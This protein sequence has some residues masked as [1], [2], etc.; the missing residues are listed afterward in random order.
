MAELYNALIE[1]GE[2]FGIAKVGKYAVDSLRQEKGMR[3]WG[4]EV[5][6]LHKPAILM[7]NYLHDG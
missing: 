6:Q 7:F 3:A 1:A 5:R 2:E 4:R